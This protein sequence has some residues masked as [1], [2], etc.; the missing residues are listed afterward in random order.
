[1]KVTG[2]HN[3]TPAE[4]QQLI[5][6]VIPYVQGVSYKPGIVIPLKGKTVTCNYQKT[7][8]TI[9]VT[10]VAEQTATPPPQPPT[11][12]NNKTPL[13]KAIEKGTVTKN[14]NWYTYKGKN[15]LGIKNITAALSK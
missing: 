1:M 2:N 11:N 8:K 13:Q 7:H 5:K 6:L 4:Q 15:Y 14:G 9:R 12:T 10:N 3:L